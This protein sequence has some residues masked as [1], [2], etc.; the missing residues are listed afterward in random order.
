MINQYMKRDE[1]NLAIYWPEFAEALKEQGVKDVPEVGTHPHHVK[2]FL[3]NQKL[4]PAKWLNRV[5]SIGGIKWDA[6]LLM[7]QTY[8]H[9][10]VMKDEVYVS[11]RQI[12]AKLAN[13]IYEDDHCLVAFKPVGMSVHGSFKGEINTLDVAVAKY[14]LENEDPIEI[15]H[16]HRLDDDTSGP[17]LYAKHDL[18]Q[19]RLDEAMRQKDID[20][21]YIAIVEGV[22]LKDK[23]TIDAPIGKNRHNSKARMVSPSG[24]QAI[25]HYEV[26]RRFD[27]YT[28]VKFELE[29]GRTHQ[30]RVHSS[31]IGHPIAG[32]G[33]YGAT[34][35]LRKTQA[36][37]GQFLIFPHPISQ[38][39]IKVEAP[40]PRWYVQLVEQIEKS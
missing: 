19:Q 30:I 1:N 6:Q 11:A 28:E 10:D 40:L 32:D 13:I 22:M 16:I 5:F 18:A 20:R 29:T 3:I 26:V 25:T 8:K 14:M 31:Y 2:T 9:V 27:R 7:I 23:G 33:L 12:G 37:H 15:R 35:E 34:T 17:V 4:F 36:L 39:Q 24:E 21:L 38:Q